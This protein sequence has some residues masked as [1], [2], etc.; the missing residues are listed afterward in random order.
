MIRACFLMLFSLACTTT[1]AVRRPTAAVSASEL[2]GYV[3]SDEV[4]LTMS[5][6]LLTASG[7]RV[8]VQRMEWTDSETKTKHSA[9]T[10]ALRA[11]ELPRQHGRGALEGAGTGLLAG[12]LLGA[13]LGFASG[14]DTCPAGQWCIFKLTAAQKAAGAGILLG[15]AGLVIGAIAGAVIGHSTVLEFY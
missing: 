10:E 12:A 5:N 14:D 9:P 15:G 8:G 6:A 2:T 13:G 7:V 11:I 1:V 4:Q 3:G